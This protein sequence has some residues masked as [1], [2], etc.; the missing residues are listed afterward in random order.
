MNH[1]HPLDH[2]EFVAQLIRLQ[3]GA[4]ELEGHHRTRLVNITGWERPPGPRGQYIRFTKPEAV[5]LLYWFW[6]Q[7]GAVAALR[8]AEDYASDI[9]GDS[10]RYEME[11]FNDLRSWTAR[12]HWNF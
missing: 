2:G 1:S 10:S 5:P 4:D 7:V 11:L 12:E 8:K 3:H 6:V 9:D